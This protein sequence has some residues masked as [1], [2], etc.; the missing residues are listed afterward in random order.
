MA[1]GRRMLEMVETDVIK[2][3]VFDVLH[4]PLDGAYIFTYIMNGWLKIPLHVAYIIVAM[5]DKKE[6]SKKKK[7]KRRKK[8]WALENMAARSS[9]QPMPDTSRGATVPRGA[10]GVSI[11]GESESHRPPPRPS[12]DSAIM[13]PVWGEVGEASKLW[14]EP[15]SSITL[16]FVNFQSIGTPDIGFS[17]L[18]L[19]DVGRYCPTD[20]SSP[21]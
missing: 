3:S 18:L 13:E 11:I 16:E 7:G 14:G 10:L 5:L 12:P 8:S 15:L 4:Y 6:N 17:C 1:S 2:R 19:E 21:L 20:A 9:N